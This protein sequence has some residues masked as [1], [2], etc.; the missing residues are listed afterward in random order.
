[1]LRRAPS[2]AIVEE[3][4]SFIHRASAEQLARQS[5]LEFDSSMPPTART[6]RVAF[7]A[8]LE[9]IDRF[10]LAG[11][12]LSSAVALVGRGDRLLRRVRASFDAVADVYVM[13]VPRSDPQLREWLD[14][15]KLRIDGPSVV[16][17]ESISIIVATDDRVSS[18]ANIFVPA[19]GT[20]N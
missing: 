17:A 11:G 5:A 2:V 10:T 6:M 8:I 16:G 9:A 15:M 13:I 18:F 19:L 3:G 12:E 20:V 7:P 4:H 14:S 1:M